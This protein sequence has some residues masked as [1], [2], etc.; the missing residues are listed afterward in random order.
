MDGE[1]ADVWENAVLCKGW[2]V[3]VSTASL[4]DVSHSHLQLF[5]VEGL[6]EVL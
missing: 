1:N 6:E 4:G 3:K 5:L 2:T